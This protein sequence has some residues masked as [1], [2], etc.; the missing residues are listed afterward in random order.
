MASGFDGELHRVSAVF[1]HREGE[2]RDISTT[3]DVH[4]VVSLPV[5]TSSTEI[6]WALGDSCRW[7]KLYAL[8]FSELVS[9]SSNK[10]YRIG[11]AQESGSAKAGNLMVGR[12]GQP[13]EE[14]RTVSADKNRGM[15]ASQLKKEDQGAE[16]AELRVNSLAA[17]ELQS[18]N[19]FSACDQGS[20]TQAAESSGNTFIA[21]AAPRR[22]F[23]RKEELVCL[24]D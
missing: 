4:R 23:P 18:T 8:P 7:R 24:K 19:R 3:L 6:R 16:N 13:T 17:N 22:R 14:T 9:I 1:L 10:L 5:Q 2:E 15:A 21:G 12:I 11:D 20:F